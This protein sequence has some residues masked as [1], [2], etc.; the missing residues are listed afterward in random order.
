MGRRSCLLL[1]D[2]FKRHSFT[3]V[4]GGTLLLP[5]RTGTELR[6]SCLWLKSQMFERQRLVAKDASLKKLVTCGDG[7]LAT[8]KKQSP[9]CQSGGKSF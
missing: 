8:P 7:R 3:Q 9:H 2:D 4:P 6:F 5:A 1:R